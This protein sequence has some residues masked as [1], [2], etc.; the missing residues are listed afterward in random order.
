MAEPECFHRV[1]A[2]EREHALTLVESL[3]ARYSLTTV[4]RILGVSHNMA[5]GRRHARR[6]DRWRPHEN[7]NPA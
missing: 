4:I 2:E 5:V 1:P 7:G 3:L 6:D